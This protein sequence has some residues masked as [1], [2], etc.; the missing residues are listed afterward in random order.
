M[1]DMS[2]DIFVQDLPPNAKTLEDIPA[3][4]KPAS[5]GKRAHIIEKIQEVVPTTDFSDPA[6]GRIRGDDWSIEI[7]IGHEENCS[8]LAFHVRGGDLSLGIVE[9]ILRALNLRGLDPQA[10]GFF[11]ARAEAIDSFRRWRAYRDQIVNRNQ[12]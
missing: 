9:A 4:F 6:W 10:G 3:D 12:L 1:P 2:Y 5:I 11:V 8:G 7:N